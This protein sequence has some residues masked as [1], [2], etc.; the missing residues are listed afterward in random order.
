MSSPHCRMAF[1]DLTDGG[2]IVTTGPLIHEVELWN[3][4]HSSCAFHSVAFS[5]LYLRYLDS[6]LGRRMYVTNPGLLRQHST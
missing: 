5:R 3:G 6:S 2:D 1:N 4:R